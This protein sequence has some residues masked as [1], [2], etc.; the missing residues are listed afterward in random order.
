MGSS[1]G[2]LVVA[3]GDADFGVDAVGEAFFAFV[4]LEDVTHAAG[5]VGAFGVGGGVADGDA[6]GAG[7]AMD[8]DGAGEEAVTANPGG[9]G[10]FKT[11]SCGLEAG[12]EEADFGLSTG[13]VAIE[14]GLLGVGDEDAFVLRFVAA[15]DAAGGG[16]ATALVLGAAVENVEAVAGDA[17]GDFVGLLPALEF[18]VGPEVVGGGAAGF[19]ADEPPEIRGGAVGF[20]DVGGDFGL[21]AFFGLVVGLALRGR[22]DFDDIGDEAFGVGV[23]GDLDDACGVAG[24]FAQSFEER[25]EIEGGHGFSRWVGWL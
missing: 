6:V 11:R 20:A 5:E 21:T 16:T 24:D 7:G 2:E 17:E 14:L 13:D 22:G 3:E 25:A 1:G 15:G 9:E 18:H 12:G 10:G 23:D 19:I 4:G 8:G